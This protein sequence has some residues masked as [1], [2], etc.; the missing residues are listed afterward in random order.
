MRRAARLAQL[1]KVGVKR[2]NAVILQAY[3]EWGHPD[4][5]RVR[6]ALVREAEKLR[7]HLLRR[8]ITRLG[9]VNYKNLGSAQQRAIRTQL[10]PLD[11]RFSGSQFEQFAELH[12]ALIEL[13]ET[14]V[15]DREYISD[16][17]VSAINQMVPQ[18]TEKIPLASIKGIISAMAGLFGSPDEI[19]NSARFEIDNCS[20]KEIRIARII[21]KRILENSRRAEALLQID[22]LPNSVR[23]QLEMMASLRPQISVGPWAILYFALCLLGVRRNE[24]FRTIPCRSANFQPFSMDFIA[25][26]D[27]LKS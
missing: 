14:G 23:H 18:T 19:E 3:L 16:L 25:H 27:K 2:E 8:R 12:A 10:G 24:K 6:E 13:A 7:S 1:R 21:L 17:V 26:F 15:G 4:L 20:K 9:D 5:D 22:A 11:P